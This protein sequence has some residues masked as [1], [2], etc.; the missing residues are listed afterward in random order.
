MVTME[1]PKVTI[2]TTNTCP[3][4]DMAKDF[5]KK[6]KI[7]FVEKDVRAD[8]TARAEAQEKSGQGGVTVIEING[9]IIVGFDKEAIEKALI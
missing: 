4:C 5:F 7:E 1:K 9:Q 6:N 8:E 3:Y 2:Y